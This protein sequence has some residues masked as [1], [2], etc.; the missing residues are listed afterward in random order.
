MPD[1]LLSGGYYLASTIKRETLERL[2]DTALRIGD[3]VIM[4]SDIDGIIIGGVD[5][6]CIAMLEMSLPKKSFEAFE[7]VFAHIDLD[8]IGLKDNLGRLEGDVL[9]FE[10]D[11]YD[12]AY[13]GT[14]E[15]EMLTSS[16]RRVE[17]KWF[18]EPRTYDASVVVCREWL[19]KV[20]DTMEEDVVGVG[21]TQMRLVVE[22]KS[23]M[24]MVTSYV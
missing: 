7:G 1:A 19:M 14:G 21:I 12:L 11:A 3:R 9:I 24:M 20:L 16:A 5:P 15:K 18:P 17:P 22:G 10:I 4:V 23:V 8:L 2:I 6:A 13:L